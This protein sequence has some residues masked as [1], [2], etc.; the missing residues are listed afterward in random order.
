MAQIST[1]QWQQALKS[2]QMLKELY[3]NEAE[4]KE[5]YEQA[6][7]RAALAQFQPRKRSRVRKR[8]S[9]RRLLMGVVT[10]SIVVLAAYA[11]YEI[12]IAPSI[13]EE[14]HLRQITSLRSTVDEAIIAGDYTRARESLQQL[15][16]ILPE[17][18]QTAETLQKVMQLEQASSLYGEAKTLMEA[19]NWD[20]AIQV[21][22]ELQDL[23]AEYRDLSELLQVARESQALDKQF[24]AADEAFARGDWENAIAGYEALQENRLTFRFEEVQA[25]LFEAFI[26]AG[27]SIVEQAGTEQGRVVE[28]ISYFSKALKLRPMD[29]AALNERHL[30]ETYL[31]ALSSGNQD[32]VIDLLGTIYRE[33]P[34]YAGNQVAGLLYTALLERG[35][36]FVQ[37]GNQDAAIADF[38]T[39]AGLPVQDVSGAQDKL[40]TLVS[41]QE[42]N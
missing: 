28:A 39:A 19:G 36:S 1:G 41:D 42:G 14:L 37:A 31:A 23:D 30:A 15:Q 18:S 4:V 33:R 25:R 22:T 6:E 21:L 2:F 13:T 38:Q 29:R 34:E 8:L 10:A 27:Q 32:E 17:D 12:W 3:P 35:D 11:A 5:L 16:S 24:L 7:M 26:V 20:E 9:P 40:N